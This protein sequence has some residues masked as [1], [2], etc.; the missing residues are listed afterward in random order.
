MLNINE[1]RLL[2]DFE[3]LSRIGATS[4]GGVHRPALSDADLE[5]RAWFKDAIEA[6]GFLYRQDGAGNLSAF[7]PSTN[8]HAKILMAG[9]HLDSVPNGGRFDGP[10][11]VLSALE[12]LRTIKDAGLALPVHLEAISFTDEEGAWTSLI[13][14]RAFT[15]E[16]NRHNLANVRGG[17]KAFEAALN[18]IGASIDGVVNAKRNPS[19][20]A[21][22]VEVHIE[23]G[24]RLEDA[25]LDIGVVTEIVGIRWQWLTFKGEAAHAGTMP[26]ARRKDPFWGVVLFAERARKIVSEKY[27]PGVLNCGMA[28]FAPGAFNIVPAEV[29]L[30]LEFRHGSLKQ[31]DAMQ[32]EL[33]AMA[34]S[35]AE[36][37]GLTLS[38][39]LVS[40]V[41]PAPLSEAVVAA[42]EKAANHLNLSHTRLMSFAGHDAQSL[43]AVMPAAMFFVPSVDGISHNPKEFTR[44]HDVVNAANVMLHALLNLAQSS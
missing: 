28:E 7:F 42:I 2:S 3:A 21:G 41:P 24:T 18:S 5:T 30:G 23:Q 4:E 37:F 44:E 8:P 25:K 31:M 32:E 43:S 35:C 13:G 39:E 27:F 10:L 26:L 11:G 1:Y 19:D 34:K 29:K 36:E 6:A 33:F 40:D 14:S 9:S 38:I 16:L 15:G 22:F 17:Q 12:A 20:Y